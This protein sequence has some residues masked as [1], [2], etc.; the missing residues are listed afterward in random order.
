VNG[1]RLASRQGQCPGDAEDRV[2]T[3]SSALPEGPLPPTQKESPVPCGA[4]LKV[5]SGKPD[6]PEGWIRRESTPGGKRTR[7]ALITV[8]SCQKEGHAAMQH[9]AG[10]PCVTGMIQTTFRHFWGCSDASCMQ[11]RP[12]AG[13]QH[14]CRAAQ[15]VQRWAR[16]IRK[17]RKAW[18]RAT[19]F[20]SSG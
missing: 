16:W 17:S 20:I 6:T 13:T 3:A 11:V 7:V 19:V 12:K 14:T 8:S 2:V 9:D 15:N 1:W 18:T 4:G 10:S 5:M